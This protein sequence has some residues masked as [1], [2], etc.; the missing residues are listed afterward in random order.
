V[1]YSF[2]FGFESEKLEALYWYLEETQGHSMRPTAIITICKYYI[3]PR[4]GVNILCPADPSESEVF[5]YAS[6][7]HLIL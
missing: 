3:K 5:L 6:W 7:R 4:K 1:Q 2:W